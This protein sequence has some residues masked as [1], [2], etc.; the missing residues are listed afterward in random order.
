MADARAGSGGSGVDETSRPSMY[1][2]ILGDA[3]DRLP[4]LVRDMHEVESRH[5]ARGRGRVSR[6]TGLASR[7]MANVLGMPPEARDIPVETTFSLEQGAETITR[8]Y[9][10]AILVTRQAMVPV[11]AAE[12]GSPALL[13]EKFGPVALFIRLEG[14]QEGI[15]FHLQRCSLLGLPLPRFLSPRLVA[16]ER[17]SD[18]KYHYFVRIELPLVGKLIEYEGLLQLVKA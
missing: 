13:L 9:N 14:T 18:G 8:N 5:T 7:L 12:T 10:G 1:R 2:R 17:M 3:Y 6:G 16:R 15:T 4:P 11:N